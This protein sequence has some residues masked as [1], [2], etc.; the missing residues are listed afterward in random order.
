MTEENTN[1]VAER[2]REA[3]G[4]EPGEKIEVQTPQFERADGKEIDYYPL[5]L[6]EFERLKTLTADELKELGLRG[7]DEEGRL[8]LFPHEWFPH[9]PEGFE[10]TDINKQREQFDPETSDDDQRFGVLP[11]GVSPA[12]R[13]DYASDEPWRCSE[14]GENMSEKTGPERT[15]HLL[16]H[17][18]AVMEGPGVI[19]SDAAVDQND[20]QHL[21]ER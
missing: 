2:L 15:E 21:E 14:C 16:S 6:A 10:V 3:I 12:D 1:D 5:T 8:W 7:W 13:E 11:Y 17:A 20:S 18:D 19:E 4:A 9:I